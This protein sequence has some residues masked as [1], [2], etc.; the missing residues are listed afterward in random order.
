VN[1]RISRVSQ[2]GTK[3]KKLV[4]LDER[5]QTGD[6]PTKAEP[7][8]TLIHLSDLHICDAQGPTRLEFI[9]RMA[10]PGHPMQPILH[11]IGTYRAQ[12]FL[13]VQV[14]ESMVAAVN[15]IDKGPLLGGK[16]DA[17][18]VTGD[19]TDNAQQNELD[20]YKT[21]L[22]GGPVTPNS[23]GTEFESFHAATN[24]DEYYYHPDVPGAD[25]PQKLYD[26][27][28]FP[29]V[30]KASIA[31]FIAKGL[32]HNWLAIHGNHDS[33]LQGTTAPNAELDAATVGARKFSGL[34]PEANLEKLI[35]KFGEIGPADYPSIELLYTEEITADPRRAFTKISDWV[36]LHTN[37]GHD[38]GM[39]SENRNATYYFRDFPNDIRL[40]ALDTVN[41]YGGWQGCIDRVQFAWLKDLLDKSRDKY[42]I[43]TSHH[44]LEKIFNPYAPEGV[45][46][47]AV[48]R[49]ITELL[50]QYPNI[51]LWVSGHNHQNYINEITHNGEHAFWHIRTASHI[52]WPQQSRVIEIA[53]EGDE[54]F[55]G[56]TIL[57][58]AA[59]LEFNGTESEL[60]DPIALAAFSRQLAA[61]DWQRQEGLLDISLAEGRP[62]D[63]N[64]WL[65]APD[66]FK[67]RSAN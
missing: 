25:R 12:E 63:Q 32:K 54:I 8:L 18:I 67:D 4:A 1:R 66:P 47:P 33:L 16:V 53:R 60:A 13:T 45:A 24:K 57:D 34:R 14:L 48:R 52:D 15:K 59:P 38:H 27:P 28:A 17:V 58:H 11:Y 21:V 5:T 64:T 55:I 46:E 40:I 49:E 19:M 7:L 31:P 26:F 2:P 62:E 6:A 37:C 22:D 29:G 65:R 43:L 42:L 20:W 10:D 41:I 51:I 35:E 44:P 30:G 39:S 56:T 50:V 36:E 23:G 9:D 3:W 61:N